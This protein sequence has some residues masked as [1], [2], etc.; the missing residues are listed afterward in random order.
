MK[1]ELNRLSAGHAAARL[2]AGDITAERLAEDCLARIAEREGVVGAGE[3]LDLERARAAARARDAAGPA[4][5]LHGIPIG[6]KDIIDTADMPTG[7][8]SPI[9]AGHRPAEDAA[10]VAAARRAGAV[11]LG[12][13]VT[14]EFAY[15]TPGKTANPRN[16]AHTPGG[17]SSGSAAAVADFM[18]PLA[19]ASQ[20]AGS[21][22]RP[23]AYC[24]IVGFKPT[25]GRYDLAGLRRNAPSLDTLGFFARSVADVA[26]FAA[27][28]EG[29]ERPG[30]ES[31]RPPR[32]GLCRTPQWNHADAATQHVIEG[33]ARH[34]AAVGA[35]VL[36][37][38]LP[39]DFVTLVQ[40]QKD[41][42]AYEMARSLAAERRDHWDRLSPALQAIIREGEACADGRYRDA[43][44]IAGHCRDLLA[45]AFG[46]CDALLAPATQG[47]APR[48]LGATGD[49]IFNRIWTLLHVP[50]LTI[51][52][53]TGPKGLPIGIQLI[54]RA[55]DDDG[56]LRVAHWA[57]TRLAAVR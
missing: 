17:S 47:E 29:R 53:G 27:A 49:P 37:G 19:F 56:L 48:G 51:P 34:L 25:F 26:L 18:V 5:A 38:E 21:V 35:E 14:T 4:G 9:H 28:I 54:G 30:L 1:E 42:M 7:Y 3:H 52:A 46:K 33:T 32:I 50:C 43:L 20:T 45:D 11:I 15:F 41:I 55:D 10:C 16:V 31:S 12:K 23:A 8:G 22:I 44:T 24:G 2:A 13:T 40:A 6:V 36:E 57:E 39:A